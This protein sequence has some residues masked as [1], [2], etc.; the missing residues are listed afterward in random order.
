MVAMPAMSVESGFDSSGGTVL[1][2]LMGTGRVNATRWPV[3][4]IIVVALIS[5]FTPAASAREVDSW[6]GPDK[7]MH[8][9]AGTLLAGASY[10]IWIERR[11]GRGWGA[12]IGAGVGLGAGA[13]KELADVA[14]LGH[15]S[16]K[17]FAWTALGTALGLGIAILIDV[18][19]RGASSRRTPSPATSRIP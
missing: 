15:P 16:A 2:C 8:L 9:V 6:T 10:G 18:A 5:S 13:A 4:A 17:D 1:F 7:A 19:V 3:L 12:L 14:G 11:D